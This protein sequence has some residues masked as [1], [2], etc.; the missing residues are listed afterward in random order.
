MKVT[1]RLR[2]HLKNPEERARALLEDEEIN[3]MI[4][5]LSRLTGEDR[6]VLLIR[7]LERALKTIGAVE[8]EAQPSSMRTVPPDV[9]NLFELLRQTMLVLMILD[10]R[11]M[12]GGVQGSGG[13]ATPSAGYTYQDA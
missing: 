2:R 5:D 4:D 3:R 8:G 11:R 9:M 12:R 13:S 10:M 6:G 1:E 7:Y